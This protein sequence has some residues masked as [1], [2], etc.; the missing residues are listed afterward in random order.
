MN[1]S[2][3][4]DLKQFKKG[5]LYYYDQ[6]LSLFVTLLLTFFVCLFVLNREKNL[7]KLWSNIYSQPKVTKHER[8]HTSYVYFCICLG[9]NPSQSTAEQ[10]GVTDIADATDVRQFIA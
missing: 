7:W 1:I 9:T 6:F 2:I 8:S 4:V 10:V 5:L 3:D